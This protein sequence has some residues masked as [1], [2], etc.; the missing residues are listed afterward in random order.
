MTYC[1]YILASKLRVL[2]VGITRD[3]ERRVYQH[4]K[5]LLP[6][7]TRQ[8]NVN[9]LVYYEFFGDVRAAIAREKQIKAWRREKKLN[10]IESL[11]P[12]WKDLSVELFGIRPATS[13]KSTPEVPHP[14]RERRGSE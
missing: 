5:K 8:Y 2:Y 3:L 10:L 1:V 7:F 4:Q 12:K 9:Q 6:G 14:D 13:K 11:N